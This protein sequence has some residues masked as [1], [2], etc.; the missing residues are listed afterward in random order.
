ML[1]EAR[2]SPFGRKVQE[3]PINGGPQNVSQRLHAP[4]NPLRLVE[5]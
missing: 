2:Q 1:A 5:S 4:Y 3:R